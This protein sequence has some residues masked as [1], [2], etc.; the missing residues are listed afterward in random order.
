LCPSLS[1]AA[2]SQVRLICSVPRFISPT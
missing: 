2:L 1:S